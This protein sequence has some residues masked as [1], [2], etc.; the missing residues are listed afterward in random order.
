[1]EW[2]EK[3]LE[4]LV[5]E[6][7]KQ[8]VDVLDL[9]DFERDLR[10]SIGRVLQAGGTDPSREEAVAHVLIDRAFRRLEQEW[11]RDRA[12]SAF[13]CPLCR[14]PFECPTEDMV[15]DRAPTW[16]TKG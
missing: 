11:R 16:V 1:M 8:H 4:E 15:T 7:V 9:I 5:Y 14:P 13:V 10:E 12:A 6:Q 2:H 3:L